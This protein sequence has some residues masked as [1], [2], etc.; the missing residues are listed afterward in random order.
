MLDFTEAST[1]HTKPIL[2]HFE[3]LPWEVLTMVCTQAVASAGDQDVIGIMPL[4][5]SHVNSYLRRMSLSIPQLWTF[6]DYRL[7]LSLN[8]L[9]LERSGCHHL[10]LTIGTDPIIDKSAQ[11]NALL[12]ECIHRVRWLRVLPSPSCR[13]GAGQIISAPLR[14]LVHRTASLETLTL[15]FP[16]REFHAPPELDPQRTSI[17]EPFRRPHLKRL[18]LEYF[19]TLPAFTASPTA[20]THL[21]LLRRTTSAEL[22]FDLLGFLNFT[23]ALEVLRIEGSTPDAPD[24]AWRPFPNI[25]CLPVH[26]LRLRYLSITTSPVKIL[27][28]FLRALRLPS[29]V[30]TRFHI[31]DGTALDRGHLALFPHPTET[32]TWE[33]FEL[34]RRPTTVRIHQVRD[35]DGDILLRAGNTL[36]TYSL[37][38][39]RIK[40]LANLLR[41]LPVIVDT[42]SIRELWLGP[43]LARPQDT[44]SWKRSWP[45]ESWRTLFLT[46]PA[47]E[48]LG[49]P[50]GGYTAILD[51]LHPSADGTDAAPQGQAHSDIQIP[52]PRL[53]TIHVFPSM[54]SIDKSLRRL[55]QSRAELNH[56]IQHLH[57]HIYPPRW[58]YGEWTPVVDLQ[59]L[60]AKP[61]EWWE[62]APTCHTPHTND[63]GR[64]S[65]NAMFPYC[66]DVTA[67]DLGEE[68]M[69]RV[70][71]ISLIQ[72]RLGVWE[73]WEK[74]EQ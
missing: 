55:L 19:V 67:D 30:I 27:Q 37:Q 39:G 16:W 65:S 4:T 68:L 63:V 49:L 56:P 18:H 34:F 74:E 57:F 48:L 40:A 31:Q 72:S 13:E 21:T 51:S 10:Y 38:L 66:P 52:C 53:A 58:W 54:S 26:L 25:S 9:F 45:E 41:S 14:E 71:G 15:S 32:P 17:V 23:P 12:E 61:S 35:E 50:R 47:L 7:P 64:Q 22:L 42:S 36:S 5:S 8:R 43:I 46:L 60:H 70:G 1:T 28:E 3:Q 44:R 2:A 29:G 59:W 6:I 20:L 62:K 73:K 24:E 11:F 33:S 69:D